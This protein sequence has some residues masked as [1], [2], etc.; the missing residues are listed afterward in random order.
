MQIFIAALPVA[1]MRICFRNRAP[2]GEANHGADD[3]N[4]FKIE[5]GWA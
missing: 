1:M 2:I 4:G 3:S 5:K